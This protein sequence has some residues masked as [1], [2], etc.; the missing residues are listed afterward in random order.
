MEAERITDEELNEI[1][2][3]SE[4]PDEEEHAPCGDGGRLTLDRIMEWKRINNRMR[5]LEEEDRYLRNRAADMLNTYGYLSDQMDDIVNA[6][7]WRD[8][9]LYDMDVSF[10]DDTLTVRIPEILP[11][12]RSRPDTAFY[13]DFKTLLGRYGNENPAILKEIWDKTKDGIVLVVKHSYRTRS[14]VR[15]SDNTELKPLIDALSAFGF[16][17]GDRGEYMDMF[18]TSDINESAGK[19]YSEII[20]MPKERF[21]G[22][23][24]GRI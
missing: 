21:A 6:Q 5:D 11:H 14:M 22:W 12:R 15:D 20:V 17:H 16:I 9:H 3:S 18:L 10:F 4:I 8:R 19:N 23:V 7:T 24:S 13:N 1:L 2:N